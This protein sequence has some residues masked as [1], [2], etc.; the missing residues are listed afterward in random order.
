M[1]SFYFLN[2]ISILVSMFPGFSP[3]LL[4]LSIYITKSISDHA[5]HNYVA[6]EPYTEINAPG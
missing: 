2:K 3:K 4:L 1:K 6:K 5:K